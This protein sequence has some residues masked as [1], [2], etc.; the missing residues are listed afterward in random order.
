MLVFKKAI[1]LQ[2]HLKR[3]LPAGAAIGFVP[4]M[5]A[6]HEGHLSLLT[7]AKNDTGFSVCSIFINPAQ[8]NNPTDYARYPVQTASDIDK[9]ERAGCDV[10][11][12][13]PA[14][15]MYSQTYTPPHYHLGVVETVLEGAFR[16]G[17]FQGV[18]QAVDRLLAVVSPTDLY[19]GQKDYQQCLVVKRLL[20]LTGRKALRFHMAPT[21]R[22][23]SGLAMSSRNLRLSGAEKETAAA[24]FQTL[25]HIRQNFASTPRQLLEKEGMDF[26]KSCGFTPDYVA[27]ANAA[28]LAAP[29]S[30]S[31]PLVALV[32][33]TLAGV[34]LIDN[35][36]LN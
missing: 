14:A 28:T 22:E 35:L 12:L 6:L 7:A 24:L 36:I 29:N 10:L 33:A 27:I 32:A 17:H 25:Q 20:Q 3:V 8:F 26:L 34:R 23:K 2:N 13:P 5:G 11:F 21:Q 18:C 19:M 31:E 4:T 9:L 30:A 15:E 16:P 1:A